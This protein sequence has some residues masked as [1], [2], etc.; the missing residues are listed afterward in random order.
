MDPLV[1]LIIIVLIIVFFRRILGS[2]GKLL[3]KASRL[4]QQGKYL[5]ALDI[6]FRISIRSSADMVLRTPEASQILALRKLERKYRPQQLYKVFNK[7]A[8]TYIEKSD[9]HKASKAFLFA[10]KPFAAAKAF[11]DI[12]GIDYI[13]A[14]IQIIDQNP[15]LIHNRDQAV[16]NLARH[17]YNNQMFLEAAEL[18]RAIGEE[19][20]GTAVL[21]AA[22]TELKKQGVEDLAA[23]YL[24]TTSH[25]KKAI[26]QYLNEIEKS[27]T[28]GDIEQV[29]RSL[30]VAKELLASIMEKSEDPIDDNLLE[31]RASI[32][33]SD[34]LLRILDSARDLLKKKNTNQSVA[35]Y[36]EL[37]EGFTKVPGFILAE[38]ALANE[39]QN[40]LY[41]SSLYEQAA[42]KV[43]SE[44]AARSFRVRAKK[45]KISA[46]S[47][48]SS[49]IDEE[50]LARESEFQEN[51][52]VC[53]MQII[54][55]NSMVRCP[56]CGTPA[57]Y[58]HLAEWL[59]IR[60]FCPICKNKIKVKP[61]SL[62]K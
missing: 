7:L 30:S 62:K 15:Q 61:P 12:G 27:F 54:D 25:P 33:E 26:T 53:R 43:E 35:L 38:A 47:V 34:R 39:E 21:I 36:E 42:E 13:P 20:E 60:G 23:Q 22:A 3:N 50:V 18:L 8:R 58:S 51:C 9:P 44:Q 31:I 52:S 1:Y 59:K 29:R 48:T 16:R 32:Q 6:Y 57:H 45:I 10:R 28:K 17:A 40:P 11:L 56:E 19:E 41:A 2:K 49:G 14:A 37:I 4:E 46:T 55:V 5:D 24:T